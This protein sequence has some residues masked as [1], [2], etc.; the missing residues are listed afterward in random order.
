MK[1]KSILILSGMLFLSEP[2]FTQTKNEY[3]SHNFI[4]KGKVM[5]GEKNKL[6]INECLTVL[7]FDKIRTV[8]TNEK[9]EYLIKFF[10]TTGI[11]DYDSF[12]VPEGEITFIGGDDPNKMHILYLKR[13]KI[14][15]SNKKDDC[16]GKPELLTINIKLEFDFD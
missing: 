8:C 6:L 16:T 14:K 3:Y 5:D 12:E 2:S 4:L 7:A 1:L 9:G 13:T 15:K 10:D 11:K